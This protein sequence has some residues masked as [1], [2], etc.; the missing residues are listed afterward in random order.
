VALAVVAL[1]VTHSAVFRVRD[2]TVTG[3]QHL[4]KA[5]VLRLAGVDDH[6]NVLW[7]STG[8]VERRLDRSPWIQAA[9]VSRALPSAISI[10]ITERAPAATV[11]AGSQ[12]YLVSADGLVL[13]RT[14]HATPRPVIEV[15]EGSVS[16]GS[17]VRQA[18]AAL[19]AIV[20]LPEPLRDRVRVANV[21]PGGDLVLRLEGGVRAIYGDGS[22]AG[23][24]AQALAA[25][26][27]WAARHGVA[28]SYVDVRAPVTP[29]AGPA[30][31]ASPT[32]AASLAGASSTPGQIAGSPSP[33]PSP[34]P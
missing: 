5:A 13:D 31:A 9:H 33:S 2:L 32:P 17:K 22:G 18:F 6:T 11:R 29:A 7:L 21:G 10:T 14:S 19:E 23:A 28:L 25:V 16:V 20:A 1:W 4:A 12:L 27:A 30:V 8:R 24:K 26:L 34:S 15:S 3:N